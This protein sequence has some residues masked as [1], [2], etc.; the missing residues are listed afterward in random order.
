MPTTSNKRPCAIC[1]KWFTVS[2]Q[3]RKTQTVCAEPSCQRERHRRACAA[4]RAQN[5]DYDKENRLRARLQSALEAPA[6]PPPPDELPREFWKVAR[7]A[8]SLE[9]SVIVQVFGKV[10]AR[11][12]RDVDSTQVAA[13]PM[14]FRK[15][16]PG[17]PRD[18]SD[19]PTGPP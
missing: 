3:A 18:E 5:P 9:L 10:L 14:E 16:P 11:L 4:W 17:R 13:I 19:R 8:D 1:R 7:D 6:R 12:T 2:L 15:V